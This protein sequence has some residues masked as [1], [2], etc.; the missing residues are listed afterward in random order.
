[1]QTLRQFLDSLNTYGS[2]HSEYQ[3]LIMIDVTGNECL[4]WNGNNDSKYDAHVLKVED[5]DEYGF[6]GRIYTDYRAEV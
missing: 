2:K 4:F 1:M 6:T 3:E 5:A